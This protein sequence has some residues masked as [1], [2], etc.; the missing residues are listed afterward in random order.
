MPMLGRRGTICLPLSHRHNRGSR[1]LRLAGTH[2]PRAEQR[3]ERA[4]RPG[5]P[6]ALSTQPAGCSARP[7]VGEADV[8][9]RGDAMESHPLAI[10]H[11]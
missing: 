1:L 11:R 6:A 8:L 10:V 7:S 5:V 2:R 4:Q 9:T 3:C